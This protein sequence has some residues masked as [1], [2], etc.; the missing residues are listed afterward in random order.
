MS[1]GTGCRKNCEMGSGEIMVCCFLVVLTG[2][3]INII[4][5]NG[6]C[7]IFSIM[8]RNNLSCGSADFWT[9]LE[10]E[11]KSEAEA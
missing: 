7:V 4:H 9:R 8:F 3:N 10:I 2:F 1:T 11:K 6:G 5:L